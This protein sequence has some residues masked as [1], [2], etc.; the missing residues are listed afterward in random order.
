[1]NRQQPTSS[2]TVY[3]SKKNT[4]LTSVQFNPVKPVIII[5]DD[6]GSVISFKLSPNLRSSLKVR[7]PVFSP[8][9]W[10]KNFNIMFL[11]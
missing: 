3:S 7:V 8:E 5:G 9:L 4:N 10:N 2:Y 1:M 11:D 6:K